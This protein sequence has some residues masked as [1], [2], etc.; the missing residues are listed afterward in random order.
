[1]SVQHRYYSQYGEDYLI[2]AFFQ[3]KRSGVFIDVGAFDGKH[4]SN[5]YMLEQQGWTG[6]CVEPHPEFFRR[7]Q[8]NR[9]QSH[10]VNVACVADEKL[11]T[12]DFYTFQNVTGAER[13][14][15]AALNTG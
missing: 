10:C 13:K 1:M 9:P 12:V 4:L 15:N 14:Q 8:Q 11:T 6:I 2:C 5:T 3:A 7:L